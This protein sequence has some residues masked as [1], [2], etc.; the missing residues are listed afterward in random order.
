MK[1][2]TLILSAGRASRMKQPKQLLKFGNTT[3]LGHV[4]SEALQTETEVYC[5]IGA[6]AKEV[7]AS[8]ED[9]NVSIIENSNYKTGLSSSIVSGVKILSEYDA[10]VILLSDQPKVNSDYINALL[11]GFKNHSNCIITSNYNGVNGVPAVIPKLYFS[12]LLKLKGDK[13]AKQLFNSGEFPIKTI[14]STV[15]LL[16]ID[17]PE[18]YKKLQEEWFQSLKP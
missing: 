3:L 1:I 5:V 14:H 11:S 8:I 10:I 16:D 18:D 6:Y 4:I 17:T 13:G 12:E 7:K 2:A 15:N 9:F